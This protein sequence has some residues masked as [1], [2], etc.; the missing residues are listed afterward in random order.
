MLKKNK[1]LHHIF[2]ADDDSAEEEVCVCV[3]GGYIPA[4]SIAAP[5]RVGRHRARERKVSPHTHDVMGGQEEVKGQS[6]LL[7]SSVGRRWDGSFK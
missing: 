2:I 5:P 6:S 4:L 3:G 7:L 1:N